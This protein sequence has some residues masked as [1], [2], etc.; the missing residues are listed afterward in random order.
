MR[1]HANVAFLA[2]VRAAVDGAQQEPASL[3][4]Y[5]ADRVAAGRPLPVVEIRASGRQPTDC[6]LHGLVG[7]ARPRLPPEMSRVVMGYLQRERYHRRDHESELCHWEYRAVNYD[8][9]NPPNPGELDIELQVA[10]LIS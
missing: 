5:L 10:G 8:A 7:L 3:G 6:M 9:A 4:G 2:G 1:D